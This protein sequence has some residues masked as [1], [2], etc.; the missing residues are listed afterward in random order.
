MIYNIN[1]IDN[2]LFLFK[3]LF[4]L[5]FESINYLYHKTYF[6]FIKNVSIK[7]AN[8]NLFYVKILQGIS[9]HNNLLDKD[10]SDFL[11]E[12]TDNVFFN[13]DQIDYGFYN[14]IN[15]VNKIYPELEIDK[16]TFNVLNS[17]LI[18]VVFKGKMNDKDI[19]IKVIKKDIKSKMKRSIKQIDFLINI[20]KYFPFVKYL[21]IHDIFHENKQIMEE[22]LNFISEVKNIKEFRERFK[23]IDN[24]IIPKVYE[25]F[26]NYDNNIIVMEYIKG[27]RI[28]QINLHEK[29][30]Y[31]LQLVKFILKSL[32]YDGI[33]H[34]DLHPG[35]IIFVNDND[36]NLK[37]GI[38]DFGIVGRLTKEE[39][40]IFYLFF[41]NL[42]SDRFKDA[43]EII[44]NLLSEKPDQLTI[45]TIGDREK[46][47]NNIEKVCRNSVI[48]KRN[49]EPSDIYE[50]DKLLY[51]YNMKLSRFFCKLQITLAIADS[52]IQRLSNNKTYIDN[53]RIAFELL[54]PGAIFDCE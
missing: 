16:N 31:C 1:M 38:I 25:E 39:Q 15:D 26:T 53:I 9:A 32:L 28:N 30:E 20:L 14:S 52:L 40:N 18:S 13:K 10:T 41:L 37:L 51:Q 22:Q 3:T 44:L 36:D 48:T 4:I 6:K 11:L 46:L 23:N 21:N 12:Y 8:E 49:F 24:I 19:I 7:L 42:L 50:I 5:S 54:C 45:S 43:S 27:R 29:D 47:I 2:L 33:Y 17:G 34:S 35:N